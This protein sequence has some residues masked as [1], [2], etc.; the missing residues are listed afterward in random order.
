MV[1]L[2]KEASKALAAMPLLLLQPFATSVCVIIVAMYTLSTCFLLYTAGDSTPKPKI[3]S[4][5]MSITVIETEVTETTRYSCLL[6]EL[7]IFFQNN[8]L[9]AI[10]WLCLVVGICTLL[11]ASFYCRIY[12]PLVFR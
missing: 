4:D 12:Q 1:K 7:T 6:Y 2:F 5:G 8:V 3:L 11:P 9:Y 10:S